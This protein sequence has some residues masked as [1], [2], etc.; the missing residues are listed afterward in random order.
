[1]L[2]DVGNS[3][4]QNSA[5]MTA[6]FPSLAYWVHHR[7]PPSHSFRLQY[8]IC[9][10]DCGVGDVLTDSFWSGT[11]LPAEGS[12]GIK[13]AAATQ[14]HNHFSLVAGAMI[15]EMCGGPQIW[16][17]Y[18]GKRKKYEQGCKMDLK[19]DFRIWCQQTTAGFKHKHLFCGCTWCELPDCYKI[20]LQAPGQ[21]YMW[22]DL[23]LHII[24]SLHSFLP[25]FG[26]VPEESQRCHCIQLGWPENSCQK[27]GRHSLM[28][29]MTMTTLW[30][31]LSGRVLCP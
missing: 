26:S 31:I 5:T 25:A 22:D 3:Q 23:S 12:S 11:F 9:S 27:L 14:N 21:K 8:L 17:I 13:E 29:I 16:T 20:I 1:M 10:C 7:I 30:S 19:M 6:T 18:R 2:G 24:L 4:I 28:P 15:L